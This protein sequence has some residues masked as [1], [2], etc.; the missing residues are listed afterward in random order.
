MIPELTILIPTRNRPDQLTTCLNSIRDHFGSGQRIIIGDNG[1]TAPTENVLK[2]FPEL[3]VTHLHNPQGTEYLGNLKI[4]IAANSTEWLCLMHDDDFF[5]ANAGDVLRPLLANSEIDFIFSDSWFCSNE[6]E[7]DEEKTDEFFKHYRR[8][9][10]L[11]GLQRQPGRLAAEQRI[12]LDGFFMRS[13]LAKMVS[14]DATGP[15]AYDMKWLIETADQS[16]GLYYV[17]ERL[18][19]YRLSTE[20]LTALGEP[21]QD[22]WNFLKVMLETRSEIPATKY[23]LWRLRIR[24]LHGLCG[25]YYRRIKPKVTA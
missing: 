12:A 7:R 13:E 23:A 20:G 6:G 18:F 11:E 8:N 16:R 4:L 1:E 5:N 2:L 3:N 15:V 25:A 22:M 9:E 21:I 14:I 24:S 19:T 10:L 17:A